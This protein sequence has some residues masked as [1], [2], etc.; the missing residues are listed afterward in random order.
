MAAPLEIDVK[1]DTKAVRPVPYATININTETYSGP[2]DCCGEGTEVDGS[3][4]LYKTI[5]GRSNAK[6]IGASDLCVT[7]V[8]N[9]PDVSDEEPDVDDGDGEVVGEPCP[10]GDAEG[11]T[12]CDVPTA[13]AQVDIYCTVT[14]APFASTPV[15][16]CP[17]PKPLHCC[18]DCDT[19]VPY[20][21]RIHISDR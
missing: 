6:D 12:D 17:L 10:E 5:V 19:D 4:N 14:P 21:L 8:S 13:F 16:S 2:S 1:E 7:E 18:P 15:C 20:A 3:D 11:D 9:R